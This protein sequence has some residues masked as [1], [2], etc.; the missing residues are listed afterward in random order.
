MLE[1]VFDNYGN[2]YALSDIIIPQENSTVQNR[3]VDTSCDSGI[4]RLHFTTG[5][6]MLNGDIDAVARRAVVCQVFH[7]ISEF[8]TTPLKNLGNN[9]RI[10]IWIRGINDLTQ[11]NNVL[12]MASSFYTI[13]VS[14]NITG[15]S[16]VD[17]EIWK[18]IQSGVDSYTNVTNPILSQ[19]DINSSGAIFYHGMVAINFD[20]INWNLNLNT[21][22]NATQIDLYTVVLHEVTHALGFAS[23]L[24]QNGTSRFG[25]NFNYLS[26]YDMFLKTN[27]NQTVISSPN[28]CNLLY[29]YNLNVNQDFLHP[30]CTAPNNVDDA[31]PNSNNTNCLNA[32]RFTG[33]N[34]TTPVEVYTPQCFEE[35]SSFSHFED[36]CFINQVTGNAFGDDAY[37]VMSNSNG[38]GVTKRHLTLESK[39]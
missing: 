18:T 22:A 8:I 11:N 32:L 23:L 34:T 31:N 14:T 3:F 17:N 6:G 2:Q 36:Q 28:G 39:P 37:F 10:E 4:F 27:L 20:N 1:N 5:S 15:A 25:T 29:N 13:P 19:I 38:T 16:I 21:N 26:R 33:F 7:D 24:N 12:G 30:G 9:N 35:G